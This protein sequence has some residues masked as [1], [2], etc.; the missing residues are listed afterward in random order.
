MGLA[1]NTSRR[2]QQIV[3]LLLILFLPSIVY[4]QWYVRDNLGNHRAV[5][6]LNMNSKKIINQAD[7]TLPTDGANKR[8]ITTD[9]SDHSATPDAHHVA[10]VSGDISHDGINDVSANDH[11]TP[12]RNGAN[13]DPGYDE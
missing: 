12:H 6:E 2:L 9:I 5:K 11:H 1:Y 7:P 8:T 3:F 13:C 10:T 4:S